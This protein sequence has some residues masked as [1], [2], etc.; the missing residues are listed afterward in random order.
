AVH[1]RSSGDRF[2]AN[3]GGAL[4]AGGLTTTGVVNSNTTVFEAYGSEFVDN[5]AS[6]PALDSRGIHVLGASTTRTNVASDNTVLV[7]L[8]GSTVARNQFGDFDAFGALQTALSGIAGTNNRATIAL[9]GVSTKTNV[10]A[11]DSSPV[12]ASGSNTVSVTRSPEADVVDSG[13]FS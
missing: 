12:E 2:F 13:R 3:A 5:T 7:S 8:S 10:I 11:V 1:V 6:T 9:R 4:I